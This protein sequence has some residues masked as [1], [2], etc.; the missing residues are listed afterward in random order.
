MK[1][2]KVPHV[3]YYMPVRRS[4]SGMLAR[5]VTPGLLMQHCTPTVLMQLSSCGVAPILPAV[6][7][8]VVQQADGIDVVQLAQLGC[9]HLPQRP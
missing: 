6:C 7:S 4:Y 1:F 8:H 5:R 9:S 3:W 2:R